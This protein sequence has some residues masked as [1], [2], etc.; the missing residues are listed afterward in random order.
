VNGDE[1]SARINDPKFIYQWAT[2]LLICPRL[3]PSLSWWTGQPNGVPAPENVGAL[4][5]FGA[6]GVLRVAR[7]P[8]PTV[9]YPTLLHSIYQ[10]HRTLRS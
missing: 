7:N 4:G 2:Q 10:N 1:I 5:L 6:L 9:C 8:I 3:Q